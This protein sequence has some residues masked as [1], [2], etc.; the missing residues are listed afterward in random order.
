MIDTNVI[1]D[2]LLNREPQRENAG[3]VMDLVTSQ[4]IFGYVTANTLTDI[5]Y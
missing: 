3:K 4:L 1:L 2:D 5:Y